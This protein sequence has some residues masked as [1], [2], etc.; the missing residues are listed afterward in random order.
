[1]PTCQS[2]N[3]VATDLIAHSSVFE[4]CVIITSQQTAGKGQRGNRWEANPDQNLTFSLIL[5]P[6]FLSPEYQFQLNVAVSLAVYD[7]LSVFL[8]SELKVKWSNDIYYRNQK[9]GGI[10]IENI[11]QGNR[12]KYSVVGIG[13]NVNQTE[14]S[15][16][17]ANS[18]AN[19]TNKKYDLQVLLPQILESLEV[20]YLKLRQNHYS[21]MKSE[22]LQNLYWYQEKHTFLDVDNQAFTGEII[23]I[24]AIGKLAV[25]VEKKIKYFN[26]K[27]I[28][29]V[30]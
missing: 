13:L 29:F 3:E 8:G 18:L 16:S 25:A 9:L 27:E 20:R 24:D 14:F 17:K 28:V 6:D 22:Y 4:G 5:Q 19:L 30:E 7:V 10:L 15:Y 1:M 23:G 12:I 2:T 21:Q 11:L 26:F